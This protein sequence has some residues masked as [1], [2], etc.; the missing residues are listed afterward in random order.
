M[1]ILILI[2][3]LLAS[4]SSWGACISGNCTDGI[5]T[6]TW[7]D[8]GKY[9]G[10]TK[11]GMK[12]GLGTYTYPDGDKYV[13]EFQNGNRHGHGTLV[14]VDGKTYVGGWKDGAGNGY[15]TYTFEKNSKWTGDKYVGQIKDGK[16][17]GLGTYTFKNGTKQTGF[18][19]KESFVPYLCQEM[20]LTQG[21]ETFGQ[22]VIKLIDEVNK[23]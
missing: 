4:S 9:V 10:E 5:G 15:G 13:G 19:L 1:K 21:T 23:K 14:T 18:W 11:G 8:G 3:A 12:H 6:Y 2:A 17:H 16:K 7:D 22:C 20:G